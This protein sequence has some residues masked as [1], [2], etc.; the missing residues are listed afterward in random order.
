[1][2]NYLFLIFATL[3]V[4]LAAK[5]L[6]FPDHTIHSWEYEVFALNLLKGNGYIYP[7]YGIDAV[8]YM[9]PLY[10]YF[11]F[12]VYALCGHH[13]MIIILF[14][15]LFSAALTVAVYATA[16][17]FFKKKSIAYIASLFTLLHPG[18]IFYDVNNLHPLS[19]GALLIFLLGVSLIRLYRSMNYGWAFFYGLVSGL[20]FL[21]RSICA[22]LIGLSFLYLLFVPFDKKKLSVCL[23]SLLTLFFVISPWL[24]RNYTRFHTFVIA[25]NAG[26][27]FWKGNNLETNGSNF[28]D[29]GESAIHIFFKEEKEKF[30]TFKNK[31]EIE[32]DRFFF[33]EALS[34]IRH[35]PPHYIKLFLRKWSSFILIPTSTAK[36][37]YSQFQVLS[38]Y[39]WY[40]LISLFLSFTFALQ[41]FK[42]IMIHPDFKIYWMLFFGV[43]IVHSLFYFE[44]RHRVPTDII[45]FTYIAVGIDTLI[46]YAKKS[47]HILCPYSYFR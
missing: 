46:S 20:T 39:G 23:F 36:V 38:L 1:M 8:A 32:R 26:L 41:I 33:K 22:P 29:K 14:Q 28:N 42:K 9:P 24:I 37:K 45:L 18:L 3:V 34:N 2:K 4:R 10:G 16:I 5:L 21:E 44:G 47:L 27:N 6:I 7:Y 30:E 15:C 31:N 11:C 40:G 43:A 25:N 35:N 12:F 13:P 19:L 17:Y